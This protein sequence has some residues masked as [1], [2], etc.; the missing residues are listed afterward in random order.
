[1]NGNRKIQKKGIGFLLYIEEYRGNYYDST[2]DYRH[3]DG[4]GYCL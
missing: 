1:M 4:Q 2:A 3:D